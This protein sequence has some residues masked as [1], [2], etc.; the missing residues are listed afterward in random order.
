MECA[1]TVD[2]CDT[3]PQM[4]AFMEPFTPDSPDRPAPPA[5]PAPPPHPS[6]NAE[7]GGYD[8]AV[9]KQVGK[10]RGW[11]LAIAVLQSISSVLQYFLLTSQGVEPAVAI[12]TVVIMG[13]LALV[14]WGLWFWS[15]Y[16]LFPAALTAFILYVS[17][18]LLDA[19]VDP[20]TLA[21]GI[22]MKVIIVGGLYV[23]VSTSYRLRKN[24]G[25]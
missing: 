6:R 13:V 16:A 5:P 14:F 4:S 15:K 8:I 22:I 17:F 1:K 23:A 11:L 25:K 10:A 12:A 24:S 20:Q 18:I 21:R 3:F 2:T 19:I 7:P 9:E